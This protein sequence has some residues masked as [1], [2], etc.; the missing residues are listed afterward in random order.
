[1]LGRKPDDCPPRAVQKTVRQD[2][3]PA[4]TIS[5]HVLECG[6]KFGWLV[7]R[8]QPRFQSQQLSCNLGLWPQQ[9]GIEGVRSIA[10]HSNTRDAW[11][12]FLKDSHPFTGKLRTIEC[13]ASNVTVGMRQAG[14]DAASQWI[15]RC[16]HNY[17]DRPSRLLRRDHSWRAKGDNDV[18]TNLH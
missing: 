9:L 12:R 4:E 7:H 17:G 6:G 1:M 2:G 13:D 11:H 5:R 14:N 16:R 15:T 18:G 3:Q 8:E 10:E